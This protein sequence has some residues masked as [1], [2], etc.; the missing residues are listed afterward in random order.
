MQYDFSFWEEPPGKKEV[1]R[2][3]HLY[4]KVEK[5]TDE[6]KII[7]DAMEMGEIPEGWSY[8]EVLE[9]DGKGV[10]NCFRVIVV[11]SEVYRDYIAELTEVQSPFS[12][13]ESHYY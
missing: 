13:E 1:Y 9:D 10:D 7:R 3:G 4:I 8:P 2:D 5:G 6:Y 12:D 11:M